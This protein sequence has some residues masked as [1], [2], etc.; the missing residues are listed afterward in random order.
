MNTRVQS[1]IINII[2]FKFAR[3]RKRRERD[4]HV[5]FHARDVWCRARAPAES[6]PV[7]KFLKIKEITAAN[8]F[9]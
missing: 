5:Q 6:T 3:E 8:T 1:N 4:L 9:K 2:P 7:K